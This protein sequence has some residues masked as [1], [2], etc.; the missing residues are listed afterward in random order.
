MRK[1][2]IEVN[3]NSVTGQVEWCVRLPNEDMSMAECKALL[4]VQEIVTA[5]LL[6]VKANP[7]LVPDVTSRL[8]T[9]VVD[10]KRN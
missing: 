2:T 4:E 7:K 1:L 8:P 10:G 5:A 9:C 3:M 6:A